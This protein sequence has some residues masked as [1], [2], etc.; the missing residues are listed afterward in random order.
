MTSRADWRT[1]EIKLLY[2]KMEKLSLSS[3]QAGEHQLQM[4]GKKKQTKPGL[5][6][7]IAFKRQT[8]LPPMS[9]ESLTQMLMAMESCPKAL[10]F[11]G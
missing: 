5:S 3:K 9:M 1:M 2:V 8:Q 6:E 7:W 11:W 10:Y 4:G